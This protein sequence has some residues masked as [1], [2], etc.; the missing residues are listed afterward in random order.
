M[1][2]RGASSA[3]STLQILA[4]TQGLWGERIADNIKAQAPP[5]WQVVAWAA[6]RV[7]PPIIDYP[8]EYLPDSFAPADLILALGDVSGLAQLI[9]EIAQMCGA[10]AVIAPIDRNASLPPGLVKQLEGWLARMGVSVVFP[11]PFCSLTPRQYNRTPLVQEV[12]DPII[13]RFAEFFGRP[14]FEVTV[15]GGAIASV[16]VK[17]DSAC[18]CARYVAERLVGEEIEESIEKA[19]LLHHHF[20]CLADM[21]KDPDYRDTLMHVSGNF[22]KDAIKDEVQSHLSI[23]YVRPHGRVEDPGE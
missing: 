8:E 22:L 5:E 9:P 1:P 14:E 18:G 10:S 16:E 2:T 21:N 6:P 4:V 13:A 19:G 11:K 15:E 20:P 12:D 23:V 17:R 7:L 3:D